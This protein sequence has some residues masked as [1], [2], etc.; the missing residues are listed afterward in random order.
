MA[1]VAI[2]VSTPRARIIVTVTAVGTK[3]W[4]AIAV[5]VRFIVYNYFERDILMVIS[6]HFWPTKC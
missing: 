4:T 5:K 3:W 6:M 2:V 1:G